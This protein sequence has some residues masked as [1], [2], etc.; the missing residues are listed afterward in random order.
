MSPNIIGFDLVERLG[1]TK[2]D[3]ITVRCSRGNFKGKLWF[4]GT[5]EEVKARDKDA[6]E[7]IA[8]VDTGEEINLSSISL[9]LVQLTMTNGTRHLVML[10]LIKNRTQFSQIPKPRTQ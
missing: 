2:A 9:E 5:Q 6:A 4:L 7:L 3:I 1:L 10:R 8:S